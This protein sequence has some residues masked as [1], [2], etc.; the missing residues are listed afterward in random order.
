M[1]LFKDFY[2]EFSDISF[3]ERDEIINSLHDYDEK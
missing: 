3:E 1:K 2:K